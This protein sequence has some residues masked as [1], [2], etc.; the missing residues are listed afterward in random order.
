[1]VQQRGREMGGEDGAVNETGDTAELQD[2]W[3]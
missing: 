3:E 1:M 2:R